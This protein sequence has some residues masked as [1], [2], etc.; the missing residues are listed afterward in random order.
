MSCV[1]NLLYG[2]LS[3]RPPPPSRQVMIDSLSV[4]LIDD[5][6]SRDVPLFDFTLAQ[7][8]AEHDLLVE[9][10]GRAAAIFSGEY[11]NR[12]IS[13]WEPVIEPWR[14]VCVCVCVCMCVC[15]YMCVCMCACVYVCECVAYVGNY[16]CMS[17]V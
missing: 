14:C 13:A 15:V 2:S 1:R 5:C 8:Q 6:V 7:L 4:C 9:K 16:N 10:K 12:N 3:F 11:Y 17:P